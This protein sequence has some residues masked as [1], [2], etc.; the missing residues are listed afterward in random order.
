V[1]GPPG[2]DV[3]IGRGVPVKLLCS[4]WLGVGDRG[5]PSAFTMGTVKIGVDSI[6]LKGVPCTFTAIGSGNG[7]EVLI[8]S[9]VI[10]VKDG[11]GVTGEERA[12][13]S[14]FTLCSAA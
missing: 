11:K 14:I 9:L 10:S 1:G 2:V 13:V 7:V 5:V 3:G 6:G 4:S 12:T 8:S